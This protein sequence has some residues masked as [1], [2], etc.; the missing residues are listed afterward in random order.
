[1]INEQFSFWND[2]ANLKRNLRF[3]RSIVWLITICAGFVQAWATRFWISPDGNSYLDVASVWLRGDWGHAINAFWSPVFSWFLAFYFG[4][5]RLSTYWDS[6]ALH[7]LNFVGLLL[8]L[9]TFDAF[10]RAFLR[11]QKQQRLSQGI[12]EPLPELAWWTLGYTVFLST[13]LLVLTV[14][15]TTPDVWVAVFTYFIAG[16]VVRIAHHRGGWKLFA[17]LGFALGC[18][19]LTKSFYFPMSFVFLVVAW[20]ATGNPRKTLKHAAF[21]FLTFVLLAGPWIGILSRAK[22]RFTFGDAGKLN[23]A[24]FHDR[25]HQYLFWQGENGTGIPA[26]PVRQLM[27]KPR[28]FEYGTPVAGAYPPTFDPSYWMEGVRTHFGLRGLLQ[29]LRQSAGTFF[30]ICAIQLE[31]TVASLVLFFVLP[32]KLEW[33]LGLRR[34]FFLWVPPL[35]ACLSYSI[36][37]V[38]FRYVAPFLLLLW[39]AAFASLLAVKAEIPRRFILAIALAVLFATGVRIAKSSVSD[40]IAVLA[41]QE[42]VNWQVAEGLRKLGT[43]P[44][45]RVA[46]ISGVAEA[47]WARLA[48]VKI[49]AEIP[50]GD[51]NIFWTADPVENQRVLQVFASTDARFVVAKD[52]PACVVVGGWIPLGRTGF[53]AYRLPSAVQVD[54]PA[55]MIRAPGKK[56]AAFHNG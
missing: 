5:F 22:H 28:L 7:L 37:L 52:P 27:A 23:F 16:L 20:L 44:G 12:E 38:E 48:G 54:T 34:Q 46:A 19:Y 15:N 11:W 13:S 32:S 3:L 39:V 1:M 25:I 8:S 6:T 45:D 30:Q 53:Y 10:F 41:G 4:V 43:Q 24:V 21:G 50:L 35:I 9:G 2:P 33:L 14:I 29:V 26:H 47:H 49:A 40:S 17:A 31:F 56:D 42:N 18:A 55:R 51:E 36:V